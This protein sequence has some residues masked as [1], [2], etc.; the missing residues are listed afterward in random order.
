MRS[1]TLAAL[2]AVPFLA[3]SC[4]GSESDAEESNDAIE[5][6]TQSGD[7]DSKGPGDGTGGGD[8]SSD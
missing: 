7:G 5:H 1:L 4:G 8:K 2:L 3:T 6:G